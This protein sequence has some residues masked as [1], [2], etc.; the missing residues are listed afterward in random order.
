[1][2]KSTG[3]RLKKK[4]KANQEFQFGMSGTEDFDTQSSKGEYFIPL[5]IKLGR[6]ENCPIRIS[7]SS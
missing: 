4:V 6:R 1:M 3:G 7:R 2:I 5:W